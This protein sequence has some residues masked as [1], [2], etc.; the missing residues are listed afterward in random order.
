MTS[1]WGPLG[2]MTLHSVASCYPDVPTPPEIALMSTWL[3]M[4]Q[5]TITCPSC[6]EHFGTALSGY[7][8]MY[9]T[10]LASRTDFMLFT[11]RSH[12]AVNRRLNKP[13]YASVADC[14]EQLRNNV[15]T[16]KARDYRISYLNHIRRFWRT[17]QDASGITSIKK[18]NE[19]SKI[20]IEYLQKHDNNFEVDIADAIVVLPGQVFTSQTEEPSPIVR[21]DTRNAPR[22]GLNGGRFQ[23]RR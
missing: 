19:M 22:I 4:F 3:D 7:R 14:F 2:W 23:I 10:M 18:I 5:M 12:N 8:R 16:R 20:E 13:V 21:M 1:I 6:R 9:P 17:M 11:F 15:K